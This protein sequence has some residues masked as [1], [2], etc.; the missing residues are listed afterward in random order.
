[1]G[2]KWL[3]GALLVISVA[4]LTVFSVKHVSREP[5]A[6]LTKLKLGEITEQVYADGS[7]AAGSTTPYYMPISGRIVALNVKDGERVTA[8][9]VLL[10]VD[11]A[12]LQQQLQVDQNDLKIMEINRQSEKK[13]N[14]DQLKITKD[15]SGQSDIM[16]K[17]KSQEKLYELNVNNKKLDIASL[18]KQMD[19]SKLTAV[20]SGVVTDIAVKQNAY[21]SQGAPVFSLL[22]AAHLKVKANLNQLDAN[23][24]K[25]GME[26]TITG[27]AFHDT[28]HGK[29]TFLSPIAA[30]GGSG[31][32]PSVA[33]K[34]TLNNRSA[35]LRPGY[36][37]MLEIDLP[38]QSHPLAP[39]TALHSSGGKTYLFTVK[40]GTIAQVP[41]T[42]GKSNDTQIEII[43]GVKNG[44]SIIKNASGLTN[45]EKVKAK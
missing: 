3:W 1:M 36:N 14:Y 2:K 7:L 38:G 42:T 21:I 6:V 16:D 8:G 11:T 5:S 19:H 33:V 4:V 44:A 32:D 18:Q 39:L 25:T 22:D 20:Q 43:S 29:V 28:F 15:R 31:Q 35:E 23:K 41:V 24:V 27:D 37:A 9:D 40:Q 26:A 12:D 45:G 17:E 34:V 13:T 30:A 10:S